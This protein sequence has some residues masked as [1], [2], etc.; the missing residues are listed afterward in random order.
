MRKV[1]SN[2]TIYCNRFLYHLLGSSQ[3]SIYIKRKLFENKKKLLI[4]IKILKFKTLYG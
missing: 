2:V 3:L 4:G 1:Y